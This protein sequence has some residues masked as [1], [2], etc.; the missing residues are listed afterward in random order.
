MDAEK[1]VRIAVGDEREAAVRALHALGLVDYRKSG[2]W[3]TSE[4]GHRLVGG[5]VTSDGFLVLLQSLARRV[6]QKN[7]LLARPKGLSG[8]AR[9]QCDDALRAGSDVLRWLSTGRA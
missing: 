6:A 7:S 1:P 3:A 4:A 2:W 8:K 5:S 9:R